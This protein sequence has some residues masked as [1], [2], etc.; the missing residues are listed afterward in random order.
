MA[1]VGDFGKRDSRL[2]TVG[3]NTGT[4][5][6]YT[7]L[8]FATLTNGSYNEANIANGNNL[9]CLPF[10]L[11]QTVAPTLLTGIYD[12]VADAVAPLNQNIAANLKGLGCPQL[13][14]VDE[15]QYNVFPGFQKAKGF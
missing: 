13:E 6:T 3:G 10:Q 4:T 12:N 8:S 2:L 14:T 11:V 7:S 9:E 1:D 15:N 5:N